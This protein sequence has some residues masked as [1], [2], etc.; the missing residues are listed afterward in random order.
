MRHATGQLAQRF[1][2]LRLPQRGFRVQQ[3][4]RAL[5]Q[6]PV[7]LAQVKLCLQSQQRCPGPLGNFLDQCFFVRCPVARL[8]IQ[9]KQDRGQ[10]SVPD[11]RGIDDGPCPG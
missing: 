9:H 1:E 6:C 3:F 7:H 10:M 5:L 2:L 8:R 11:Q 4:G